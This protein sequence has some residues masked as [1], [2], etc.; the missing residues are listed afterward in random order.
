MEYHIRRLF[1][2]FLFPEYCLPFFITGENETRRPQVEPLSSHQ[3][4]PKLV[5]IVTLRAF[6]GRR[7][8]VPVIIK[9][10]DL[11]NGS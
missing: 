4:P 9:V 5:I 6:L 11:T 1:Q 2:Y 3:E 8:C 10:R 7:T